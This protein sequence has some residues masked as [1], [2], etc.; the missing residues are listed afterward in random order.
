[1]NGVG[2]GALNK[3]FPEF[4]DPVRRANGMGKKGWQGHFLFDT[5][6]GCSGISLSAL[7]ELPH[8]HRYSKETTIWFEDQK[9]GMASEHLP[10]TAVLDL[11]FFLL[12][13]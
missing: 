6:C 2:W 10:N 5:R 3:R 12:I 9:K 13:F 7:D 1:M 11:K 4:P 8:V